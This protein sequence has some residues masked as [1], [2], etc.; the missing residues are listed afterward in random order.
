MS[1][2]MDHRTQAIRDIVSNGV[3]SLR[4]FPA[5]PRVGS[6]T[7]RAGAEYASA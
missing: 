5:V 3:D 6:V 2:Y 1:A 7:H 4:L